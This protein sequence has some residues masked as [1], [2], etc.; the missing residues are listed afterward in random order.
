MRG[1]FIFRAIYIYYYESIHIYSK[2]DYYDPSRNVSSCESP[3]AYTPDT[4]WRY[5]SGTVT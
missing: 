1:S 2:E 3:A 5:S 4:V